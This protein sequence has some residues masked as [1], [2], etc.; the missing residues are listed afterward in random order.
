M[1]L[2]SDIDSCPMRVTY[3][4]KVSGL[5]IGVSKRKAGRVEIMAEGQ[6][7]INEMRGWYGTGIVD[8]G[9]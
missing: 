8:R 3:I 4:K 1:I 7:E 2:V 6:A 5:D 9:R